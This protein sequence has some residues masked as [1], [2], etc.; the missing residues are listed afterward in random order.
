MAERLH[1]VA[2][3][4]APDLVP[5]TWCWIPA[6]ARYATFSFNNT[7]NLDEGNM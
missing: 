2:I 4:S 3:A 6:C 7:A 5:K 1:A